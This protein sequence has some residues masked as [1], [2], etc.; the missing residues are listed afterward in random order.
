[1]PLDDRVAIVTGGTR[2]LGRAIAYELAG[3]G[4][5]VIATSRSAEAGE[6]TDTARPGSIR[7]TRVDVTQPEDV[8]QLVDRAVTAFGHLDIAVANAGVAHS[9]LLARTTDD[10]WNATVAV[11]LTGTFHLLRAAIP[12]MRDRRHGRLI[13]ISSCMARWP[14]AG[15]AAYAATKAGVEALTRSAALEAARDGVTVNSIA[16]GILDEGMGAELIANERVWDRY[17]AH[18]TSGRPGSVNEVARVAAFLAGSQ[19]SYINGSVID[20]TGGLA[21]WT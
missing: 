20:V 10:D 2:G 11:N 14:A 12:H 8:Q 3:N 19:S 13:T 1:M 21:P 15:T 7:T 17:R 6:F 18:L 9:A 5:I 16:A 4:A